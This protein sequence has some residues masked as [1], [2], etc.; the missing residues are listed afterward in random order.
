MARPSLSLKYLF[1]DDDKDVND[2]DSLASL[3]TL[4]L[5]PSQALN[6]PLMMRIA[7]RP[8]LKLKIVWD[9]YEDHDECD[10]IDPFG[11]LKCFECSQNIFD[12][13]PKAI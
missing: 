1:D 10:H 13:F 6:I 9:N 12:S 2:Y 4:Y 3:A 7:A 5:D 8:T 11:V